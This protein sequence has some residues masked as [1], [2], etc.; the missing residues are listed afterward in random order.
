MK[1]KRFFVQTSKN[2][3]LMQTIIMFFHIIFAIIIY[4]DNEW[5]Y[6]WLLCEKYQK[7][8]KY[9]SEKL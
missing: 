3:S 5:F 9:I 4:V 7:I 1:I 8:I 2:W 6:C